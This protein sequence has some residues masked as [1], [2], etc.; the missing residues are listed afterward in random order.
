MITVYCVIGVVLGLVD[1]MLVMNIMARVLP[2][3]GNK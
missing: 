2:R 3:K 1:I